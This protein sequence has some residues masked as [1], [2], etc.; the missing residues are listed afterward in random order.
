MAIIN[1]VWGEMRGSM[2][3]ITFSRNKGGNY[4]RLRIKPTDPSSTAQMNMRVAMCNTSRLWSQSLTAE[5]RT[6]WNEYAEANPVPSRLGG[7]LTLSGHQFFCGLNSRLAMVGSN[8][9]L[10]PPTTNAPSGV[11]ITVTGDE[12]DQS[13]EITFAPAPLSIG[14]RLIAWWTLW[15]RAGTNPNLRQARVL[16]WSPPAPT[17]PWRIAVPTPTN[18]ETSTNIYV[19]VMNANGQISAYSKAEGVQLQ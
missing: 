14:H 15:R 6:A 16:A 3:G 13:I 11:S 19:C 7:W 1:P 4:A 8:P 2:G 9:Q 12:L 17:S 5:Q 18:D 10:S